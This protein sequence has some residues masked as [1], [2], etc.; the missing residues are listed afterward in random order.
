MIPAP[1][2]HARTTFALAICCV[3]AAATPAGAQGSPLAR[4]I[5]EYIAPFVR[6]NNFSGQIVVMRGATTLYRREVGW[7]ERDSTIPMTRDIQ[8]HIASL[9]MQFTAAAIMRLVD[10][11]SLTLETRVSEVVPSVRGGDRIS[12]RNLLEQRSGLPDINARPDY[13]E[14]LKHHQTPASLVAMIGGDTLLFPPGSR[15]LHEEHSAYNLLALIIEKKTKMPYARAMQ[16]LVFGPAQLA[17]TSVDDDSDAPNVRRFA[18]GYT[19][20]GE[21]GLALADTIHWS[22]KSGNASIRSTAADEARL[23]WLL[24]HGKFLSDASRALIADTTGVPVGYGWFRRPSKRFNEVAYSVSG[25]SPGFASYVTYLPRED[26]I[27]VALSN[28][29]SSATSDVGNDIA[30][31]A[32][33]LPPGAIQLS[34]RKLSPDTLAVRGAR[35]TFPSDFYQ[36]N[37]TLAFVRTNGELFLS[38]PSGDKTPVIALDRDHAIDRAYW[39]PISIERDASGAATAITYDRFRGTRA[40]DSAADSARRR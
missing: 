40:P 6:S 38:W 26:L 23:V 4:E 17:H 35:F 9:S 25:R 11:H 1:F 8:L 30:A 16:R 2:A 15:Y 32:G 12:I 19:P 33:G 31:I 14:I 37:A 34:N 7:A 13:T 21:S 22:A 28:I 18:T 24:F 3:M 10:V 29:Y 20:E 27:V 39:E 5:D 36:P